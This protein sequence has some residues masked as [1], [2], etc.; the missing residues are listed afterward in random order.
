MPD[1]DNISDL[2]KSGPRRLQDAEELMQPPTHDRQ[3]SDA[4]T[5]HLRG[6]M[7]LSGYGVECLL[8][9]YLVEQEGCRTLT[10]AQNKIN[11]RRNRANAKHNF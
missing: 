9:A 3:R 11:D 4:Q 1:F 6:A 5:R 10:E 2:V 7:Y 8:K